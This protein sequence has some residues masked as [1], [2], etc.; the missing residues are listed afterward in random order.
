[1]LWID[2][3]PHSVYASVLLL[4]NKIEA[5]KIG[6]HP[7]NVLTFTA[8]WKPDRLNDYTSDHKEFIVNNS[9]EHE[10]AFTKLAREYFSQW[11]VA[12]DFRGFRH[13]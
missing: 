8:Y 11:E 4:D 2:E 9:K 6:N 1:M 13:Y 5:Y 10:L 7:K 3:Y 12:D